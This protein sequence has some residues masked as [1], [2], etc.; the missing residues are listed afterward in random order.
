MSQQS[1]GK[2]LLHVLCGGIAGFVLNAG[3]MALLEVD[4]RSFFGVSI[5]LGII[6]G[7]LWDITDKLH[8]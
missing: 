8:S 4:M 5:L 7:L 2:T 1:Q 3:L 6:A